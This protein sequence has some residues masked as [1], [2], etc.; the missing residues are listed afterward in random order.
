MTQAIYDSR[1][2]DYSNPYRQMVYDNLE[3]MNAAMGK[4]LKKTYLSTQQKMSW[5]SLKSRW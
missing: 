3:E 5:S 1:A 2:K 4:S